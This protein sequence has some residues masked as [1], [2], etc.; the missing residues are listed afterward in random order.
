M[1]YFFHF[2]LTILG[3]L[4]RPV[5][6]NTIRDGGLEVASRYELLTLLALLAFDK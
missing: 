6:N 3:I 5:L 1:T 4:I 2:F